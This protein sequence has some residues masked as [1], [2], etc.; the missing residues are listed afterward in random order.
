MIIKNVT[1]N[2]SPDPNNKGDVDNNL[3]D[4]QIIFNSP[5]FTF[6]GPIYPK[7]IKFTTKL[8]ELIKEYNMGRI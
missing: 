4:K 8:L 3:E 2:M 6:T 1:V 5:L 7:D